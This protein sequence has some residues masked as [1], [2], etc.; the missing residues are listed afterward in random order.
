MHT[1]GDD[2]ARIERQL[3]AIGTTVAV[4]ETIA[5]NLTELDRR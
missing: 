1:A 2:T 5:A 3:V 4:A